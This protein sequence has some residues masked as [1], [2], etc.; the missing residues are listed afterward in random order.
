[1]ALRR[2]ITAATSVT[3]SAACRADGA[4]NSGQTLAKNAMSMTLIEKGG[5][6][7]ALLERD[8]PSTDQ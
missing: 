1:V 6:S 7:A 4:I 3:G 8:G 5:P 2:F